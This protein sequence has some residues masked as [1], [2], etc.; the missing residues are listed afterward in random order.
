MTTALLL[1][2]T[3]NEGETI[4]WAVVGNRQFPGRTPGEALDALLKHIPKEEQTNLLLRQ[5]GPDEFFNEEKRSRLQFLMAKWRV[6]R[7]NANKKEDW[8]TLEAEELKQLTE[9]E[10]LASARRTESLLSFPKTLLKQA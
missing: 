1:P 2:E 6:H 10:I 9:E 3:T 4:F 5:F 7:D 8:S